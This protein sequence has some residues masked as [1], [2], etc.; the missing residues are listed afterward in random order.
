MIIPNFLTIKRSAYLHKKRTD[1]IDQINIFL[2]ELTLEFPLLNDVAK[3]LLTIVPCWM[4]GGG[5]AAGWW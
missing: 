5:A 1:K 3:Q 2:N 4:G